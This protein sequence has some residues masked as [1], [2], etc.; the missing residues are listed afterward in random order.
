MIRLDRDEDFDSGLFRGDGKEHILEEREGSF[1]DAFVELV[2]A[3]FHP[4]FHED[5]FFRVPHI[6]IHR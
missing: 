1:L 6:G 3:D 4:H 2:E 5:K